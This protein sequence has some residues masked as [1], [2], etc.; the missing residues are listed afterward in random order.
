MGIGFAAFLSN[1][2]ASTANMFAYV[3]LAVVAIFLIVSTAIVII[4]RRKN[5]R[6]NPS[7]PAKS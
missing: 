1:V 7:N 2:S 5:R 4:Y 3:I 6:E